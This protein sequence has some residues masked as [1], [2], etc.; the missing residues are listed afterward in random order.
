MSAATSPLL[1]LDSRR[2]AQDVPKRQAWEI[3]AKK[4]K[5]GEP[6]LGPAPRVRRS[7]VDSFTVEGLRDVLAANPKGVLVAADE[8]TGVL[9]GLDQYKSRGGSDRAEMPRLQRAQHEQSIASAAACVCRAGAH[10][11]SAGCNRRR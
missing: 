2:S 9:S 3:A 4:Q 10:L 1:R 6:P 11:Y 5:R 7:L 8:V